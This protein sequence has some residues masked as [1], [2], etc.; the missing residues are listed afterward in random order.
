MI[1]AGSGFLLAS[2]AYRNSWNLKLARLKNTLATTAILLYMTSVFIV[3]ML[4]V[5]PQRLRNWDQRFPLLIGNEA[6]LDRP[7]LGTISSLMIFDRALEEKELSSI[8]SGGCWPATAVQK[9]YQ[10]ILAYEFEEATGHSVQ[11]LSQFGEPADMQ[12]SSLDETTWSPGGGLTLQEPTV[13]QSVKSGEKIC[14]RIRDTDTFSV[15]I[16]FEPASLEQSGPARIL[17]LSESTLARNFTIG[18]EGA[19]IRFRVR[20]RLSG[21]NGTRWELEVRDAL[22]STTEPIHG[23]FEY[24]KGTK[25]V[26]IDGKKV[27]VA[28]SPDWLN[29]IAWFL[30][31]DWELPWQRWMLGILL[32][33]A[34]GILLWPLMSPREC[35][36]NY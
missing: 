34:A 35:P 9:E 6:T 16:W 29:V 27:R 3:W 1:G 32:V 25:R 13:L 4:S 5:M 12:I 11:D 21:S 7:W 8:C 15:S 26:Y 33:G 28:E 36:R 22:Q 20:D 2:Y 23:V 10:P 31:F 14:R 18:Q 19:H 30:H 17:S 24:E